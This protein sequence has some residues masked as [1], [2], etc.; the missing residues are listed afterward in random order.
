MCNIFIAYNTDSISKLHKKIIKFKEDEIENQISVSE[1]YNKNENFFSV[2]IEEHKKRIACFM[3]IKEYYKKKNGKYNL[4]FDILDNTYQSQNRYSHI[5]RNEEIIKSD[6]TKLIIFVVSDNEISF[7]QLQEAFFGSYYD[8][9]ILFLTNKKFLKLIKTKK[10][11]K[12]IKRQ[13]KSK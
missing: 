6:K 8:K 12:K 2:S 7:W 9:K 5:D 1:N 13:I 10:L 11:D 3:R 4:Y